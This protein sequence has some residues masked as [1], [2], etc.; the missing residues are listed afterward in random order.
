MDKL[1]TQ[2]AANVVIRQVCVSLP[3]V[4]NE[5]KIN[6]IVTHCIMLEVSRV[7]PIILQLFDTLQD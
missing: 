7:Y 2:V 4:P 3:L 5:N 6:I 1:P